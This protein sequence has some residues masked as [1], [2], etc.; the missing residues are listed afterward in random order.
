MCVQRAE[1]DSWKRT[2]CSLQIKRSKSSNHLWAKTG[3]HERMATGLCPAGLHLSLGLIR[4]KGYMKRA[5]RFWKDKSFWSQILQGMSVHVWNCLAKADGQFECKRGY[6]SVSMLNACN[7]AN[8][9]L[10]S[11]T[12]T[13]QCKQSAARPSKNRVAWTQMN[14]YRKQWYKQYY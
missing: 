12:D 14:H 5:N 7:W 4:F 9:R 11:F 1:K 6:A 3:V 2:A 10:A 13:W 8:A